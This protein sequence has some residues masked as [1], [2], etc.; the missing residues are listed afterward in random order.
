MANATRL[1]GPYSTPFLLLQAICKE[2]AEWK[3]RLR[4]TQSHAGTH[5][6]AHKIVATCMQYER[7]LSHLPLLLSKT[8]PSLCKF[9]PS[10]ASSAASLVLLGA[11]STES[12]AA[13]FTPPAGGAIVGFAFFPSCWSLSLSSPFRT[14][15]VAGVAGFLA[16]NMERK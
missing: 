14:L 4:A 7:V 5:I 12:M 15:A 1:T 6:Q 10:G 8:I 16:V 11:G 3:I 13:R 9:I 2:M